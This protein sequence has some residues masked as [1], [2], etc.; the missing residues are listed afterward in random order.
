[1]AGVLLQHIQTDLIHMCIHPQMF[2]LF[3]LPSF[4]YH[5]MSMQAIFYM[6]ILEHCIFCMK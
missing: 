4:A 2:F 3:Y 5:Y 1:M 6:Q